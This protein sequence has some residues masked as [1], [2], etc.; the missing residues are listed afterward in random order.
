METQP[1][2]NESEGVTATYTYRPQDG[3]RFERYWKS[4]FNGISSV[5]E[6]FTI[7]MGHMF[8]TPMTVQYPEVNVKARL[9]E[10]YRGFLNVDLDVCISCRNCEKACPIDCI[11]IEDVKLERKS[12]IGNNGK[13]SKKLLN[14][15]VF[16]IDLSKCMWCGLCVE[17]CPT[18]AIYFT[19]EFER[20]TS[21]IRDLYFEFVTPEERKALKAKAKNFAEKEAKKKA[22][23]AAA[24]AA[25]KA[26]EEAAK[27]EGGE[28]ADSS[29]APSGDNN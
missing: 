14:P 24:A 3:S 10:R 28:Q 27:A 18:G 11:L 20:S 13:P 8:R 5:F 15:T 25:K 23:K 19:R 22:E 26:E 9:P 7:T 4:L 17:P 29:A 1:T 6:A 16:N 21:N 2:T 12:I